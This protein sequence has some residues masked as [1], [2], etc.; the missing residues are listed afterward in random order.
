MIRNY[1][2][3]ALRNLLNNKSSSVINILG[4]TI[5]ITSCILIGVYIRNE[6]N[7]DKFQVNGN[8]IFRVIMEY[9]FD[10]SPA[11]KKGNFTS[12]KVAPVFRRKFPEV[13]EAVR[14]DKYS[15]RCALQG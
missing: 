4:L 11:S 9:A 13:Q 15:N 12:M 14:M 5:G 7:Y 1:I 3:T 6:L 2:R 8:R 10:G